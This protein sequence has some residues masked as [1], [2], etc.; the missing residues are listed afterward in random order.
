MEKFKVITIVIADDHAFFREGLAKVI[1]ANKKFKVVGAA[2]NGV[3]LVAL[4]QQLIPD[5][6]IVDISM[7][8]LNGI[9]AVKQIMELKIPTK[10][11]ALSMHNEDSIILQILNAGA[12][13]FLDKNTSKDEMYEAIESVYIHNRVYF[14]ESTN[15]HMMDLLRSSAY[16][17]YPEKQI[18][19][20]DRELEV[21]KMVC[22]DF[23]SK[24]IGAKLDLSPRTVDT[25]RLRI[26]ERMNVKSVAGLVAYAY[27]QGIIV[28]PIQ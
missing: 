26:M 19:F 5:L 28:A 12:M 14:P 21:I 27:S 22:K 16:K 24:E 8:E 9:H 20:T 2:A 13:G 7:P 11:I 18:E 3:E 17:P 23:T 1:N 15:R 10:V 25:H 6:L 4:A